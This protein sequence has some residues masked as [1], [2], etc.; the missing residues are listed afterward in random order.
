M[1]EPTEN[2]H[3]EL[4]QLGAVFKLAYWR[5]GRRLA[6]LGLVLVMASFIT[7]IVIGAG[8]ISCPTAGPHG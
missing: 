7:G 8:G 5:Y 1:Q 3:N 2:Q 4:T 6:T